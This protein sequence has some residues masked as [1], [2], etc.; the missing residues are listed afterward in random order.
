MADLYIGMISG[1]SID[2]VDAVLA[3]FRDR[4]CHIM[5]ATTTAYP[6]AL[7]VRIGTLIA[8]PTVTLLELGSLDVSLGQ[9]FAD[10]ALE[11]IAKAGLKP[12][13]VTGIGHHGQTVYHH[14]AG[15]SPF[16]MQIADPNTIAIRTGITTVADFRRL[17]VAFEGQ[18]AP[19]VPAFHEWL[20][21]SD[22]ETRVIVNIGGIANIT[23]LEP[24]TATTGFDTGPGNTLLDLWVQTVRGDPYDAG[25]AWASQGSV[26]SEL[27]AALL[28]EPYFSAPPPKSTGRE[29]FNASW[30]DARLAGVAERPA[31]RDVQAT[32]AELTARTVAESIARA[33]RRCDRVVV[34]GGGAH[35]RHLMTR[36]AEH[37]GNRI[38][39][40][41]EYG[42]HEDWMEGAA[43]AWLARQRL[44]NDVSNLPSVTGARGQLSLG[45]V[46]CPPID[47][48]TSASS[49]LLGRTH[50]P[51]TH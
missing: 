17:D 14:P 33:T 23:V 5:A 10:C 41:N 29:R 36:L 30:L 38:E 12:S 11:L 9:F 34:C 15:P 31:A 51:D 49:D 16:T 6:D 46:Y 44:A 1:T 39:T 19:L 26:D 47:S 24:G 40:T 18:G 21:R 45:G 27:L 43:F 4:R 37:T 8:E 28:D 22:D 13:D 25:G 35:N 7:K 32:L 42:I 20:M 50:R 2:G 48:K 3:E